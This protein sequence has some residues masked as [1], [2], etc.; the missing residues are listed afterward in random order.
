MLTES[1][2]VEILNIIKSVLEGNNVVVKD[3]TTFPSDVLIREIKPADY[4]DKLA[5]AVIS[6]K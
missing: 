5:G 2:R 6:E 1:D 4:V 3:S